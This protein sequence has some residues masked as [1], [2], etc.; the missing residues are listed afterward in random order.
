M[1]HTVIDAPSRRILFDL[2]RV[3]NTFASRF[4]GWMGKRYAAGSEAIIF[5]RTSSLHTF[6]MRFSIDVI[7]LD[8]DMR[9]MR[10]VEMIKP[11]R[12]TYCRGAACA[13]ECAGGQARK[14]EITPGKTIE[15]K[16]ASDI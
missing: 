6:F 9:V 3:A 16:K 13:I 5:Y 14:K 10:V 12:V 8:R 2:C 4:L 7:Y 1:K 15:I 11:W